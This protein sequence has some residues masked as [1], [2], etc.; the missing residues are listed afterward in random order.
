MFGA[1]NSF[2]KAAEAVDPEEAIDKVIKRS[3][4]T[5][6]KLRTKINQKVVIGIDGAH[7]STEQPLHRL[8]RNPRVTKKA[9]EQLVSRGAEL[10]PSL[11]VRNRYQLKNYPY[12]TFLETL[13]EDRA[14]KSLK[15]LV[16]NGRDPSTL[17]KGAN[18]LANQ[19]AVNAFLTQKGAEPS[20]IGF[21]SSAENDALQKA[22][23]VLKIQ[24]VV[25]E[26]DPEKI[27]EMMSSS[28][29]IQISATDP[30]EE[31]IPNRLE[32]PEVISTLYES[33]PRPA[34]TKLQVHRDDFRKLI[35]KLVKYDYRGGDK[36]IYRWQGSNYNITRWMRSWDEHLKGKFPDREKPSAEYS[37]P[38]VE[39]R[40]ET[41]KL[42]SEITRDIMA[43]LPEP[44]KP[45]KKTPKPLNQIV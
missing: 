29:K 3:K 18:K 25:S 9:V 44:K 2:Y 20:S 11:R 17:V 14:L 8:L 32:K 38:D 30:V 15:M 27:W 41:G 36:L 26:R 35:H 1:K 33:F 37:D 21:L 42:L 7:R 4:L 5:P 34:R 43:Q 22:E 13:R 6:D 40:K 31:A 19:V 12:R 24:A 10:K 16:K 23:H 39:H 28:P 45:V